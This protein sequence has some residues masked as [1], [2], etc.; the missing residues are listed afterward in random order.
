[1]ALTPEEVAL[2]SQRLTEAENALHQ[3]VIGGAARVFVDQ[4]GERVEFQ[5]ANASRL[6]GYIY[7]LKLKLGK[8]TNAMGPMKAWMI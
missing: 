1:M 8:A 2:Y 4:N 5:A 7:E 3:L 6:R